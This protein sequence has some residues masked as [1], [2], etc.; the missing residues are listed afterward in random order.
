MSQADGKITLTE[1]GTPVEFRLAI[2]DCEQLQEVINRPRIA[3]GMPPLGPSGL[4][5]LMATGDAW[6][7]EVR[8]VLRLGLIGAGMKADRALVL[9]KRH[10]EPS[11]KFVGASAMACAVLGA[12]LYGVPDDPVGKEPTPAGEPETPAMTSQS[13]LAKSTG[14]VLQ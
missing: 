5:R 13:G 1:W 6:P 11:G 4:F 12:A 14:S 10:V 7:H 8:E 3:Q 9:I 2:A